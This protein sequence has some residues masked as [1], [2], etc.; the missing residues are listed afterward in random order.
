[1]PSCTNFVQIDVG[2]EAKRI[3]QELLKLGVI[4]RDM[5]VWGLQRHIRV[6][7]GTKEEN[8]IFIKALKKVLC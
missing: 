4:I 3:A 1:E 8:Q 6:T 5:T 2:P 7:I